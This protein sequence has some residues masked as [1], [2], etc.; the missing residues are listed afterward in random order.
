MMQGVEAVNRILFGFPELTL[1]FPD[2]VN[3]PHPAY[4][5]NWL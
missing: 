4:G 2:V 1:W 5:K 3:N